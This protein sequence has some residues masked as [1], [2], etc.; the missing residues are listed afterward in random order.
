MNRF[1][2]IRK[3]ALFLFTF[4]LSCA[5]SF[6]QTSKG[7]IAGTVTDS[8]GAVISG[9]S[10][11]AKDKSGSTVR[12]STT[13]SNGQYRIEA[14]QPS[15]YDISVS[16]Q[17]FAP[18]KLQSVNVL[19]SVVTSVNATLKPGAN[20]ET[21][22]VEASALGIETDSAQLSQTISQTE[23]QNLPVVTLNPLELVLTE[24]GVVNV[25]SRDNFTNGVSYTVDGLR[26]RGNGFLIDGFYNVDDNIHGQAIQPQNL[27]AIQ[28]VV[29][30]TNSY[31]AEFGEGGSSLAN[32]IYK[33][34]TN[35][36]HGALWELYSGS[37][38]NAITAEQH[39]NGDTTVPRI[40]ENT[41]G[42][43]LGGPLVKSKLF[44]FGTTQWQRLYGQEI[45]NQL[46]VP[47]A[48]GIA[49]LKSIG[50]NQN[51]NVL[52]NSLGGLTATAPTGVVDIGNRAGCNT[53][54]C[55]VQIGTV[56]RQ[57]TEQNPSYEY[58]IRTDFTPTES[59]TFTARFLAQHSFLT[60]DLFANP[61]ALPGTDT[62]QGGP[63]HNLGAYWT[64][65]FSNR[66]INEI[67]FTSQTFDINFSPTAAT[68]ANPFA[69][70]PD[71]TIS[72]L[73][74]TNL[75]GIITGFPQ[76]RNDNVFQYQ[77]AVSLIE[78]THSIKVGVD[79]IHFG[80]TGSVPFNSRGTIAI[81]GG[82]DCSAV[83]LATCTGLANFIDN[84]SGQAGTASIN[85]GNG[86]NNYAQTTQSYY[87]QDS[88][89]L[90]S[91]L[92]VNYGLRYEYD[93]TP[94]NSLAFPAVNEKTA[95][96]DPINA[97]VKEQPYRTAFG[98][99]LGIAYTPHFWTR[100]FGEDKTA[101]RA[102]FG[103]F[104]DT[105]FG[106]ITDNGAGS[107]PNV[108][109]G[110]F[111]DA[112]PAGSP[113]RGAAN[114]AGLLA[115]LTPNLSPF[116]NVTTA[117]A[118]LVNPRIYQ[119]NAN[120]ERELPGGFLATVA[121]VGTRGE[122]LFLNEELNPGINNVRL[123]PKRGDI[124]ARS[125][126]GD[127]IYHGLQLDV[128]RRFSHGF[129]VRGSY[130]FSKSLDDG[131]EVFTTSGGS[132]RLQQAFNFLGD[133]G[134]SAFDRRHRAVF[135]W[136]YDLPHTN[137]QEGI[138]RGLT[139]ITKGWQLSGTAAFESGA[140]DTIFFGGA[141]QNGD[142]S[143]FNDRPS[144]G[145]PAVP[146][147]YTSCFAASATC[148]SG[149]G[150]SL[151]GVHFTD[152]NSSFDPQF[153]GKASDFHYLFIQGR[154]GNVGRNSF[155]NPGRQDWTMSIQRQ[156]ALHDRQALEFRLEA[157]NPFNHANFGGGTGLDGATVFPISTN[158]LDPN[159]MNPAPSRE[160][161]RSLRA[162]VKYSF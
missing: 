67:R 88:W 50:S 162:W 130:T 97:V 155:Y 131:S 150:F 80:L 45:G 32:V 129:L 144:L 100:I 121:Y 39:F 146:I 92:T 113:G 8:S 40:T 156:V 27:E 110:N 72:D 44:V 61:G 69:N 98:P 91:N 19:A 7:T 141:D 49:T 28:E 149:V 46:T 138:M 3:S 99:R 128:N 148:N 36:W 9:A 119:W 126:H 104:Y 84:F 70:L 94:L 20:T 14:V 22:S 115:G 23:V 5:M 81:N 122:H 33:S 74:G 10:V 152:F 153:Q 62:F 87:A 132:T 112:T 73:P 78:G 57:V 43:R 17:G 90:R 52:L 76:F 6:A 31:N 125:N 95:A 47:T 161:G 65:V 4:A 58:D 136:I 103:T 56:S 147:N 108:T 26:P 55:A 120:I 16:A 158:I 154:N 143:G 96:F 34:G 114:P 25:S 37:G 48:A 160:G 2:S 41:F 106:N 59:D 86:Q 135:T 151:D 102:G 53:N 123:D 107:S 63:E 79:L 30:Q 42:Y 1:V 89:K 159:F 101:F 133:R 68:L 51:V 12:E 15:N 157:F 21:V 116:N 35:T 60:P 134:P 75:G 64:H 142:L 145:N 93:G 38:Y 24:P 137:G 124:L 117:V 66:V 82:G 85:F 109:G 71:F 11:T 118:N 13:G 140:P 54:P 29:I 18:E 77:D 105:I 127:S 139:Y 83:G 111:T